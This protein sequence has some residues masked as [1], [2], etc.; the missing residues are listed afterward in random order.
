MR[1]SV[2]V[3]FAVLLAAWPALA[4]TPRPAP[5]AAAALARPAP[6]KPPAAPA[7]APTAATDKRIDVNSAPE[8]ELDTLPGIGPVRAKAIIANRPYATVDAL[9]GKALPANVLASVRSRV[10]LA[11]INTSSAKDMQQVLPGIGT[12]RAGQIV[13]GR[14]YAAPG[15]LVSKG[16]LTQALLDRIKDL[17]TY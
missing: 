11:D 2:A 4:Q 10:A 13:A 8:A 14:P 3:G 1:V 15:D 9:N 12:V 16:V 6:A 17:V 7:T 5:P